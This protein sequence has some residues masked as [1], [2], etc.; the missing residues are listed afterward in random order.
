VRCW[1][2]Q[3]GVG[4]DGVRAA[5]EEEEEEGCAVCCWVRLALLIRRYGIARCACF[6]YVRHL[7]SPHSLSAA[8]LSSSLTV[9]WIT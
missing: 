9:V 8:F 6:R 5:A 7:S 1:V 4:E 2:N 3:E